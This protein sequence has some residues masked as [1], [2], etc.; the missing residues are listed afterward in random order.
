MHFYWG[1][2]RASRRLGKV[3]LDFIRCG[4]GGCRRRKLPRNIGDALPPSKKALACRAELRDI[5]SNGGSETAAPW[6]LTTHCAPVYSRSR[7]GIEA[8]QSRM[9]L[10]VH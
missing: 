2:K 1:T 6:L 10:V 8:L 4:G 9:V 5:V 7:R 3:V